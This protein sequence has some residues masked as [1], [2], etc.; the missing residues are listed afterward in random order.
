MHAHAL[1]IKRKRGQVLLGA[2]LLGMAAAVAAQSAAPRIGAIVPQSWP[3]PSQAQEIHEGML[4]ALKTIPINPAPTLVLM[5][6]GCDAAKAEASAKS[7]AAAKVDIVL[8]G[9]CV[10]GTAPAVL[11]QAGIP[12]VSSN[13]ERFALGD[14]VL[15]T[16]RVAPRVAETTAATLRRETGL[17]V[18]AGGACWMDFAP[19]LSTKFDAAL[20]PTLS[21]DKSRW[22]E[23][24]ALYTAAFRKP[25]TTS[26]ARGY[27][28]ME[29]GLAYLK[30]RRSG[31]KPAVALAEARQTQTLLGPVPEAD[32]ATPQQA[33]QLLLTARL[34]RLAPRETQVLNTILKA[35][36]CAAG[37]AAAGDGDAKWRELPF[38]LASCSAARPQLAAR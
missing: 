36:A 22:P 26:A 6:S 13:A 35:K 29:L 14:L 34:P 8:G 7:L 27:A 5:D 12:M 19:E 20:C 31:A 4:L 33:M 38:E 2:A 10:V 3:S 9:W 21:P 15:Q 24:E 32:A 37:G 11:A 1:S 17:R 16:G 18:T 30:K 23:V 25:F 28:A